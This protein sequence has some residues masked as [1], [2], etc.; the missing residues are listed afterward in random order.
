MRIAI[1]ANVILIISLAA[2]LMWYKAQVDEINRLT[3]DKVIITVS[4][5]K[6]AENITIKVVDDPSPNVEIVLG[7]PNEIGRFTAYSCSEEE[8]TADCQTASGTNCVEG[9]TL[10]CPPQYSFGTKILIEGIGFRVCEDKGAAIKSI[11]EN[12]LTCTLTFDIYIWRNLKMR[13]LLVEDLK[14]IR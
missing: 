3:E 14:N 1:V 9:V 13:L 11:C 4:E 12:D 5:S 2:I 8:G 6:E 10:A 7:E